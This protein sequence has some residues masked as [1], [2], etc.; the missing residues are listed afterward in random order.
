MNFKSKL[1]NILSAALAVSTLL[2]GFTPITTYAAQS[3]D[4]VDPADS[5]LETNNRT[6][7]LDANATVTSG[8][9]F[10]FVCEK[11]TLSISYRVPE[12]TKTGETALNR[13]VRYSDGTC[14]DGKSHGNLD[15][16]RPGKNAYYTGSHWTKAICQICGTLNPSDGVND[17]NFN[18]NVY[19]LNSCDY[20]FFLDFDNTTY[21][22]YSES[23]HTTVLKAGR[24]CQFCKGTKARASE[25]R[26]QH[27]FSET[28]DGQIG[29]N[30]FFISRK[31]AATADILQVSM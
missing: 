26:E 18:R 20:N 1:K 7:E 2:S 14:F 28:V 8:T 22:P 12:Y 4:Y 13:G 31:R 9:Q 21:T 16:G 23:Y 11:D 29:N 17:Y 6:N 24:Y 15:D 27:D 19:S 3:N 25:K 10:C 5:W 30:R